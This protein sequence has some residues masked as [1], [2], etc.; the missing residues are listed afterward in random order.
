M[1]LDDDDWRNC[2]TVN[3]M[4]SPS[5]PLEV[6]SDMAHSFHGHE[7]SKSNRN[8]RPLIE[9]ADQVCIPSL[10]VFHTDG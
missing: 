9:N 8:A 7:S 10:C 6:G 3:I 4:C 2:K 1:M 5:P